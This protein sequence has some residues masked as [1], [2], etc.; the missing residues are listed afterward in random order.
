MDNTLARKHTEAESTDIF[1]DKQDR[2]TNWNN[3]NYIKTS[4]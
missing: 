2:S 3:F 4:N 1:I